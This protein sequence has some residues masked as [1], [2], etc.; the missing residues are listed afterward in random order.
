MLQTVLRRNSEMK[1]RSIFDRGLTIL[2]VVVSASC[3]NALESA[4]TQPASAPA[5]QAARIFAVPFMEQTV[6][7]NTV[8]FPDS[9]KGKLVLIN[10]WAS[11]CPHSRAEIRFWKEA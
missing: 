11:W 1:K 6:A 3:A 10:F 4:T 7:G 5:T 9:Y 2:F 8:V